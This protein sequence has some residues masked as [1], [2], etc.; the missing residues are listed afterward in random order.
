VLIV[1]KRLSVRNGEATNSGP[2]IECSIAPL[3]CY[4]VLISPKE[5]SLTYSA[6]AAAYKAR[7][8]TGRL[9]CPAALLCEKSSYFRPRLV[10]EAVLAILRGAGIGS[11]FTG[12][13]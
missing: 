10:S 5:S 8:A 13:A 9:V 6:P 3:P 1:R 11:G 12:H 2:G 4:G 7:V